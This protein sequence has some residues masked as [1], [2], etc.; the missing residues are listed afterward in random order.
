MVYRSS[1]TIFPKTSLRYRL[2]NLESGNGSGEAS[3]FYSDSTSDLSGSYVCIMAA[4]NPDSQPQRNNTAA[5]LR[6]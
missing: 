1:K 4:T 5:G 6:L 3:V 2:Y